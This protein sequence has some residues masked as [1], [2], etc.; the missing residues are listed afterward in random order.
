MSRINFYGS[1]TQVQL[2]IQGALK[3]GDLNALD[4]KIVYTNDDVKAKL[5]IVSDMIDGRIG[6][7]YSTPLRKTFIQEETDKRY[8]YPIDLIA[9]KMAAAEIL[10]SKYT[11]STEVNANSLADGL[12]QEAESL[13]QLI[14]TFDVRLTLQR[15]RSSTSLIKPQNQRAAI[16]FGYLKRKGATGSPSGTAGFRGGT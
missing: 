8:P 16:E 5:K 3:I 7:I 15:M 4:R 9:S 14:L 2:E 12:A 1:I 13:I 6:F 10:R 11:E